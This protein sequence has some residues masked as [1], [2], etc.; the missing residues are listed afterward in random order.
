MSKHWA[1][2]WRGWLHGL[3]WATM[4]MATAAQGQV[5]MAGKSLPADW[6]PVQLSQTA[7]F[8]MESRYTGQR[9]R[10]WLG[11]PSKP[12]PEQGYPVLW[13][14]DGQAS[15]PIME[16]VRPRSASVADTPPGRQKA[17]PML[18]GLIVAVG[19]ASDKPFDNDARA[20]DYT[21][22]TQGPTGDLL[23]KQHGGSAAF[24]R[25]LTEELRPYL[26]QY[27]PMDATRHTLFGFSYGG[28]FA[29]NTLVTA[30]QHFQ[31]Y[32]AASPSLWF[33][34]GEVMRNWQQGLAS[35]RQY[36]PALRVMLTVGQE[37]QFPSA[38]LPPERLAHL[39]ERAMVERVQG[40]AQQLTAQSKPGVAVSVV[41]LPAHD[42][43]DMLMYGVRQ[44]V[45]FAFAP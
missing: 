23:S 27:F 24:L 29:V 43:H 16:Y 35:L 8:D 44:V 41:V 1:L 22:P 39:Q 30:P 33:G 3:F 6:K 37:E 11:L 18:P 13:M 9:Y 7:S 17:D 32:W 2:G 45:P 31:R 26:A 25:F 40:F 42:H 14:L 15:F 21:P 34:Q 28:L 10:I 4:S 20:Q 36:S 38:N 12:A 19:Y 5:A